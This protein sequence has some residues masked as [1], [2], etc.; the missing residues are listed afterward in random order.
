MCTCMCTYLLTLTGPTIHV[1]NCCHHFLQDLGIGPLEPAVPV[2][3]SSQPPVFPTYD[4]LM[5]NPTSAPPPPPSEQPTPF[6]VLTTSSGADPFDSSF[7][8]LSF[9]DTQPTTTATAETAPSSHGPQIFNNPVFNGHTDNPSEPSIP[10]PL[11]ST[12]ESKREVY[13]SRPRPKGRLSTDNIVP[14]PSVPA[15]PTTQQNREVS[16]SPTGEEQ[17]LSILSNTDPFQPPTLEPFQSPPVANG[18]SFFQL[19]PLTHNTSNP[20]FFSPSSA[21]PQG[22]IQVANPLYQSYSFDSSF[23]APFGS[24]TL[25]I[26]PPVMP[27][28]PVVQGGMQMQPQF[29]VISPPPLP[30]MQPVPMAQPQSPQAAIF[31]VQ[32]T[33]L[34]PTGMVPPGGM[35]SPTAVSSPP[36]V[37]PNLGSVP[38]PTKTRSSG[39]YPFKP[40]EE[41]DSMFADLIPAGTLSPEKPSTKKAEFVKPVKAPMPSLAELQ[42]TKLKWTAFKGSEQVAEAG[43]KSQDSGPKEW[44]ASPFDDEHSSTEPNLGEALGPLDTI[45]EAE[46]VPMQPSAAED[47]QVPDSTGKKAQPEPDTEA[48]TLLDFEAAFQEAGNKE[49]NIDSAFEVKFDSKPKSQPPPTAA[50]NDPFTTSNSS[51]APSEKEPSGPWISF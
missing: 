51:A 50:T 27:P 29:P 11:T 15:E 6:D 32:G 16:L 4:P 9:S 19:P 17:V 10:P 38:G 13:A 8:D 31:A 36:P 40:R 5:A 1:A 30:A 12:P 26:Q 33:Q 23:S 3:S 42:E 41:T 21:T 49:Y 18:G 34:P 25:P 22:S 14:L 39:S 2:P 35:L 24:P 37:S 46:K 44:P 7:F 43:S 47:Q 45:L 48:N 28:G 20:S